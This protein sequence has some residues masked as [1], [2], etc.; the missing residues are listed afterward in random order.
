[1]EPKFSGAIILMSKP[2]ELK[3]AFHSLKN[4]EKGA[5]VISTKI[6]VSIIFQIVYVLP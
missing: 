6:P 5:S 3:R 2:K 4:M 1:M